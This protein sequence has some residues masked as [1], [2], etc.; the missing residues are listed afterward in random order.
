MRLA[1]APV[2]FDQQLACID[3]LSYLRV[4]TDRCPGVEIAP[5]LERLNHRP[6]V[7]NMREYT[8]LQLTVIRHNQGVPRTRYKRLP[9]KEFVLI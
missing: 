9:Y 2:P 5:R 4:H 1:L 6:T 3:L 8:E 7:C